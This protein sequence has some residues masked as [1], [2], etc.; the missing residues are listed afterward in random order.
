MFP[1]QF[2]A[3]NGNIT[4]LLCNAMGLS[5]DK[6]LQ[7]VLV[8]IREVSPQVH[9]KYLDIGAGH[10]DLIRLLSREFTLEPTA[11]D[12]TSELMRVPG[13]KV[14]VVD[15]NT[16][17][18]PYRDGIFDLIT[19]TEVIEHIEHYR[20]TFREILRILKPGGTLVVTTPNVL[21]LRSRIRYL[22]FGFFSLFGPLHLRESQ[23]YLTGGHINPVSYFYVAHALSDAGFAD[24]NVSIDKRQRGSLSWFI[25]LWLPIRL[26]SLWA[27][28][29]EK[30]RFKTID[31][32]NQRFVKEM[33]ST[34]LLLGRTVVVGCRK[35]SG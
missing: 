25:L 16:A 17:A 26:F 24:I 27:I 29:R 23:R 13:I 28:H 18:L 7:A 12:Y 20:H 35:K 31:L 10:G 6:I 21:N 32:M 4:S 19:C 1:C 9:G 14:D 30:R 3:G 34:D 33:N 11:C 8:K 22:L 2:H 15:L 5:T